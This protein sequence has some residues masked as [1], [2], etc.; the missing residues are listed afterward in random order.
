LSR[1]LRLPGTDIRAGISDHALERYAQRV[2]PHLEEPDELA[3]DLSRLVKAHG[4]TYRV[5]PEWVPPD[6]PNPDDLWVH[7]GDVALVVAPSTGGCPKVVTTV[8]AKGGI[9]DANRARRNGAR[10]ART[11][12]RR[13]RGRMDSKLGKGAAAAR[14][15]PATDPG[16]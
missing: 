13:K 16:E 14:R 1:I 3:A 6:W 11:H 5:A 10:S 8:L 15:L 7:C 9:S 4:T 12:G 2:R